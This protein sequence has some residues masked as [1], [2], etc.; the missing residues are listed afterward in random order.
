MLLEIHFSTC[1]F[2]FLCTHIFLYRRRV[3]VAFT[4]PRAVGGLLLLRD[5]VVGVVGLETAFPRRFTHAGIYIIQYIVQY[6]YNI[7]NAHRKVYDLFQL[8][9]HMRTF[10]DPDRCR[11]S[12]QATEHEGNCRGRV[13]CSVTIA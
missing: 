12:Q 11:L 10:S 13:V 5:R 7:H 1:T 8:V 4:Q 2:P 6:I 9:A 3:C